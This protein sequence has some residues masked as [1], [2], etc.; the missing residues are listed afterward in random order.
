MKGFIYERKVFYYEA[1]QMGIVH[2]SN[3]IRWMEE[4]RLALLDMLGL[5]YA[6]MEKN[7]LLIPVLSVSS[8]YKLPFQ[9]GDTF[10][11]Q[12]YPRSFNGIK[13]EFGYHM[14]GEDGQI[15][16][17]AASSHCFTDSTLKLVSL[18]KSYPDIYEKMKKWADENQV[19]E[20]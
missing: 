9:Y 12:V 18:K 1:D 20:A 14:Y 5:S 16:N 19:E 6:E 13:F 15:H 4:S 10:K 8:E 3:Y 11:I 7:G 2:H 17:K